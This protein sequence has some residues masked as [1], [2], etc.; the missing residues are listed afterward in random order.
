MN[1]LTEHKLVTFLLTFIDPDGIHNKQFMKHRFRPD[2]VSHKHKFIV[3][4]D[5]YLHYTKAKTILDDYRKDK[6]I[7][8][9][10]Y[11]IQRIPYFVQLDRKVMDHLFS[12][13]MINETHDYIKYP[14]GFI[15]DKAILP[16][17]FCTL[18]VKRF[19]ED[20]D[21]FEYISKE[22]LNS[23]TKINKPHHE[24]YPLD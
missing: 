14:H 23:L 3:E 8:D 15:D 2:F 5:G 13:Y 22:I 24:I 12:S 21:K 1:Y 18:G 19:K 4:F 10:G 17:D 7:F 6:I 11:T 9:E 20:L 16:A